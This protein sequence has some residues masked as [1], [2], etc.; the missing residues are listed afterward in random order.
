MK[1]HQRVVTLIARC[2]CDLLLVAISW[3]SSLEVLQQTADVH[4]LQ[5]LSRNRTVLAGGHNR[6]FKKI[7]SAVRGEQFKH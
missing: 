2:L 4:T 5:T 3:L 7:V 1:G 6:H